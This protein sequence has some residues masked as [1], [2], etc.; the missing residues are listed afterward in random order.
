VSGVSKLPALC[1]TFLPLL[2]DEE[3]NVGHMTYMKG[4]RVVT[5]REFQQQFA[6]ISKELRPGETIAVTNRGEKIGTF[7]RARNAAGQVPDFYANLQKLGRSQSVGQRMI[8]Q[9][10]D[11]IS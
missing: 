10:T 1:E 2:L 5:S 4:R 8:E 9:V 6:K 11:D 7:T 3:A